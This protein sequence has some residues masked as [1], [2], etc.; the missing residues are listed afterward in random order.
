[1]SQELRPDEFDGDALGEAVRDWA[2]HSIREAGVRPDFA[3]VLARARAMDTTAVTGGEGH[4]TNG[5]DETPPVVDSR[6]R[7][8]DW[9]FVLPFVQAYK[10]RLD[11]ALSARSLRPVDVPPPVR[12]AP[13]LQRFMTWG[14]AVAA[15]LAMVFGLG[16]L[17]RARL[18]HQRGLGQDTT[19][20]QAGDVA[21]TRGEAGIATSEQRAVPV[22]RRRGAGSR[23][24]GT[25]ATLDDAADRVFDQLDLEQTPS[26]GTIDPEG[27]DPEG[28]DPDVT[29]AP[30]TAPADPAPT[31]RR[32]RTR[33]PKA[34]SPVA[35]TAEERIAALDAEAQAAW[36]AGDRKRAE[37]AF[38]EIV[39]IGGRRREAQLAYGEIFA[40]VRQRGGEPVKEWRAYLAKFPRG[41]YAEDARAGLCRRATGDARDQCW[42]TYRRDFPKGSHAP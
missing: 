34:A 10:G 27:A 21:E 39:K 32:K 7:D 9:L 18:G 35:A 11:A 22:K 20:M 30:D 37:A 19:A 4:D 3:E 42:E 40:L 24:R 26:P 5:D 33:K 13:P 16:A 12:R 36:R 38:R 25:G 17:L 1:M 15:V 6:E 23:H 28:A 2:E 31:R 8:E 29:P 14:F 41:R